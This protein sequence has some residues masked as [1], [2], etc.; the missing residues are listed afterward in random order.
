MGKNLLGGCMKTKF[1]ITAFT[2]SLVLFLCPILCACSSS[3]SEEKQET[4][5]AETTEE[6]NLN[7]SE[8]KAQTEEETNPTVPLA[9]QEDIAALEQLYQGRKAY[10]GDIH[11]HP[12]AGVAKDGHRTLAQW[13]EKMKEK[14]I[15]FVAFMNHHQVAHMYESDWDDTIFI[16]GTEPAASIKDSPANKKSIHYNMFFQK[17]EDLL[18]LLEEF[19]EYQYTGGKD[20]IEYTKGTFGY[21]GFTIARMQELIASVKEKG[22]LWVNVH[23]KQQMESANPMHYWFADYTGLEVFYGYEN[24]IVGEDTKDNYKLWCQLLLKGKRIWATA[25]SDSHNDATD[26]ALTCIYSEEQKDDA[27]LSHLANGDFVCGF[28]GIRMAIGDA[29]MGSS[30]DFS[31]KRVIVSIGEIH[32]SMFREG[33]SYT[34]K[35]YAGNDLVHTATTDGKS[36]LNLAF[37]ADETAPFYRVEVLDTRRGTQPIIAIGNPIWND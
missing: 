6:S 11:C 2:L 14:K 18:N 19:P 10:F 12:I 8:T 7:T 36:P 35:I 3:L 23:P 21:P 24:G 22:G 5:S 20:G 1:R 15:D 9:T 13:K 29:K 31:G 27:Y 4:N 34:V 37:D 28:V 32:P 17:P 26:A 30:T 16:G 33:R 25:G